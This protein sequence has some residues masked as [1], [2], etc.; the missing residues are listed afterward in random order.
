MGGE[1]SLKIED[2]EK[3][4]IVDEVILQNKDEYEKR[5][6]NLKYI[7]NLLNYYLNEV[8]GGL[9]YDVEFNTA[10]GS[11]LN[12]GKLLL[13]AANLNEECITAINSHN[14]K[15]AAKF[16]F[17]DNE[18]NKQNIHLTDEINATETF[19]VVPNYVM[20]NFSY[21]KLELLKKNKNKI[22]EYNIDMNK[23]S[24]IADLFM[25][26][27]KKLIKPNE[28]GIRLIR[29]IEL[30]SLCNLYL[31]LVF[32]IY[33]RNIK[34]TFSGK[35]YTLKEFFNMPNIHFNDLVF[36]INSYPQINDFNFKDLNE[37]LE[38]SVPF[39]WFPDEMEE[40]Q[41]I[42]KKVFLLA[43]NIKNN[44]EDVPT[45][46]ECHILREKVSDKIEEINFTLDNR[47]KKYYNVGINLG[48]DYTFEVISKL[49]DRIVSDLRYIC[50][51]SD[52]LNDLDREYLYYGDDSAVETIFSSLKETK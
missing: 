12:I 25:V 33:D 13:N 38:I 40:I 23:V 43:G 5:L 26:K 10:L 7:K 8:L 3:D 50:K 41:K 35:T 48:G 28:M 17:I 14:M 49:T 18:F 46:A 36:F 32:C 4:I 34:N 16:E 51:E 44:N 20:N 24:G 9:S 2:F 22:K 39:H 19:S 29:E 45:L 21:I 1:M 42:G 47:Y 15:E 52:S 6:L 27:Y 37:Q 11:I 31:K 30:F